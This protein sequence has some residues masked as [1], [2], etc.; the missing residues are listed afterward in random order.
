[1]YEGRLHVRIE[2]RYQWI[3]P[4]DAARMMSR[5]FSFVRSFRR[6]IDEFNRFLLGDPTQEVF[7]TKLDDFYKKA[8]HIKTHLRLY[9]DIW[10]AL[11]P[12]TEYPCGSCSI[13]IIILKRE[14]LGLKYYSSHKDEIRYYMSSM[15]DDIKKYLKET[16][17][18][19][20][21]LKSLDSSLYLFMYHMY[22]L[23]K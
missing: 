10:R 17:K 23:V 18:L 14:V 11:F 19:Y 6:D 16:R 2:E 13:F 9:E 4:E 8:K 5:S 20:Y 7:E 22:L 15:K 12:G 3:E 1:M 21:K